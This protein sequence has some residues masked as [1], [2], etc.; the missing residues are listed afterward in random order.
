[1]CQ[2]NATKCNVIFRLQYLSGGQ[3]KTLGSWHEVYEGKYF[4][5]DLDLS[6]LAGTTLKFIL[7]V[8]AN[9]GNNQDF[10]IWLN[11]RLVRAGNPPPTSTASR[12]PT[13]TLT[14]TPTLTPTPTFT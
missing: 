6:S 1:S 10:A 4:P 9:G 14:S 11:P 8:D 2:H 3:I 7:V 5:I 13:I 12:T